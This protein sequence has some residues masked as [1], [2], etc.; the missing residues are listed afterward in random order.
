MYPIGFSSFLFKLPISKYFVSSCVLA[1]FSKLK[2]SC[3]QS[4]ETLMGSC[5]PPSSSKN[6]RLGSASRRI[7]MLRKSLIFQHF[8]SETDGKDGELFAVNVDVKISLLLFR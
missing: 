5:S 4:K 8:C 1:E 3:S 7:D 6:F 2:V